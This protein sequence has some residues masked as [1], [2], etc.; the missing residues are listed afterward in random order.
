MVAAFSD[1]HSLHSPF[2]SGEIRDPEALF[3]GAPA[4]VVTL[5]RETTLHYLLDKI[6]GKVTPVVTAAFWSQGNDLIAAEDWD[7]V[8]EHGAH[9]LK[10][11]LL[12]PYDAFQFL[13]E[14]YEMPEPQIELVQTLFERKLASP[15]S[16]L[17]LTASE[18]TVLTAEGV[19][20]MAE[21]RELLASVGIVLPQ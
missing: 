14:D 9:L 7:S 8:I 15:D 5:A 6:D 17:V 20:G 3:A 2:R 10:A 18:K 21:A 11:E 12:E 4:E 16:T 1:V 19:D 13:R